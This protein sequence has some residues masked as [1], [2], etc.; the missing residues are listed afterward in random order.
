MVI[1]FTVAWERL[2]TRRASSPELVGDRLESHPSGLNRTDARRLSTREIR[3]RERMLAH[4]Q[5]L[6]VAH[7]PFDGANDPV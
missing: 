7:L 5:R 1:S 4:L 2:T 3:H 6:S